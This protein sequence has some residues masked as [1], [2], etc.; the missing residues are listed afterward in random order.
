MLIQ[1]LI[2]NK[3]VKLILIIIELSVVSVKMMHDEKIK[4]NLC[5]TVHIQESFILFVLP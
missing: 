5:L 2:I 4:R 3:N 1:I